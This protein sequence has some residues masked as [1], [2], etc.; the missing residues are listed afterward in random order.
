MASQR[1]YY[2]E[3]RPQI[4]MDERWKHELQIDSLR[5]FDQIAGE[6]NKSLGYAKTDI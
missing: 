4:A 2:E 1:E 3:E 6:C 5:Q